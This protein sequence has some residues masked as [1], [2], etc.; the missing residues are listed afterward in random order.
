MTIQGKY[1]GYDTDDLIFFVENLD[2]SKTVKMPAQ[3][4]A[5]SAKIALNSRKL[6]NEKIHYLVD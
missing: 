5:S 3:V 1:D 4:V 6:V 2:R